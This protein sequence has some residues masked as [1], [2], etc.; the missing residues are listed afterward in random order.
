MSHYRLQ[1]VLSSLRS[2]L[3]LDRLRCFEAIPCP[4]SG[5]LICYGMLACLNY[6]SQCNELKLSL[7]LMLCSML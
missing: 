4:Q 6:L 5:I 3:C 1:I 7:I 2:L